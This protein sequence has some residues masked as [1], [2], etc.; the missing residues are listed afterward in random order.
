MEA[1]L[2]PLTHTGPSLITEPSKTMGSRPTPRLSW[3]R[4]MG[5]V[6]SWPLAKGMARQIPQAGSAAP[7]C[8]VWTPRFG[9]FMGATLRGNA[10]A[11][12][13]HY[14][15]PGRWPSVFFHPEL[16]L[17]LVVCRKSPQLLCKYS[18]STGWW[19]RTWNLFFH[20]VGNFIIP[21]DGLIF[22]HLFVWGS[23]FWFC[24]PGAA[25]SSSSR[26]LPHTR[27]LNIQNLTYNNF[28]YNN[29]THRNLTYNN[30]TYNN[31]THTQT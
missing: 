9:G 21:T 10:T 12:W 18:T 2:R 24:I 14:A 22:P 11:G 30:F 4:N 20:S 3:C 15:R 25:S 5:R 16:K 13:I 26:R 6:T 1:L 19:F 8:P 23:C 29:C 17:L 31:F 7:D 28:T 27:T